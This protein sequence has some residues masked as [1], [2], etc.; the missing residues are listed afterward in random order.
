MYVYIYIYIYI[1]TYIH[2][3]PAWR[4]VKL[5]QGEPKLQAV[6]GFRRAIIF[7]IINYY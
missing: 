3:C 5:A 7:I 6:V 1:C 4:E 2:S